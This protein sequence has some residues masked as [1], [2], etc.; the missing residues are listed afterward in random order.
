MLCVSLKDILSHWLKLGISGFRL[1][2]TQYLTEDPQLRDESRSMFPVEANNYQS[3]THVYTRD[4]PENVAVLT[5]WQGIVHNETNGQGYALKRNVISHL[6][7][8]CYYWLT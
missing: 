3:L 6:R 5:K 7:V 2:N 4:R 8:S 1:A